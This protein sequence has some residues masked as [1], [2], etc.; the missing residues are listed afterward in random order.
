MIAQNEERFH[1]K[2]FLS[3]ILPRVLSQSVIYVHILEFPTK[4]LSDEYLL[5]KLP[6][7]AAARMHLPSICCNWH[8]LRHMK[9][10]DYRSHQQ[11]IAIRNRSEMNNHRRNWLLFLYALHTCCVHNVPGLRSAILWVGVIWVSLPLLN[12][13]Y[14]LYFLALPYCC[15]LSVYRHTRAHNSRMCN[16]WSVIWHISALYV[17]WLYVN[18]LMIAPTST[19]LLFRIFEVFR[20]L[21]GTKKRRRHVTF[22]L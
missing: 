20:I 4:D 2:S 12:L 6:I 8:F 14:I 19:R 15:S 9:R 10:A 22:Q 21:P 18:N 1:S 5:S 16:L 17:Q 3:H 13:A 7:G 11:A